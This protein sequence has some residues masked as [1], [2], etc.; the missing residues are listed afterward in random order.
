M[1]ANDVLQELSYRRENGKPELLNEESVPNSDEP[2]EDTSKPEEE[3]NSRKQK[4]ARGDTE[5]LL[6]TRSRAKDY[7]DRDLNQILEGMLLSEVGSGCGLY[8]FVFDHI[9]IMA[10]TDRLITSR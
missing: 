1:V 5:R 8:H 10:N 7:F 3:R 9:I 2:Q 6:P 4:R